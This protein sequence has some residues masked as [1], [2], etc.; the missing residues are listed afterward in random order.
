MWTYLPFFRSWGM[1]YC[2][3]CRFCGSTPPAPSPIPLCSLGFPQ[4]CAN[5]SRWFSMVSGVKAVSSAKGAVMALSKS[6]GGGGGGSVSAAAA[7]ACSCSVVAASNPCCM[8]FVNDLQMSAI[9]VKQSC[10]IY[11]FLL[12]HVVLV[13]L[14]GGGGLR[15]SLLSA[16]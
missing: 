5:L 16:T 7:A 11:I 13:V 3:L 14:Q 15:Q 1:S 12:L 6:G 9:H 10:H 2:C 8:L 4:A